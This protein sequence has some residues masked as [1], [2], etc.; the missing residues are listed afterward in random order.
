VAW[1]LPAAAAAAV[2]AA[3]AAPFADKWRRL[4]A[5]RDTAANIACHICIAG[6]L[7]YAALTGGN[8]IFADAEPTYEVSCTVG[9]KFEKTRTIYRTAVHH[10]RIPV[11]KRTCYYLRLEFD[12]GTAKTVAVRPEVYNSTGGGGRKSLKLQ[13]GLFGFP[14]IRSID[15]AR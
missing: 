1:W 11:G 9:A 12:D 14:V 10:R 13:R 3:T 15:N 8:F 7:S 5:T 2:A 6:S 4:T